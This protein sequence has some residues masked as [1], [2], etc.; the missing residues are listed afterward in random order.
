[1]YRKN[2]VKQ[3]KEQHTT[4]AFKM[5]SSCTALPQTMKEAGLS[6]EIIG[7]YFLGYYKDVLFNATIVHHLYGMLAECQAQAAAAVKPHLF[8]IIDNN[9]PSG[10]TNNTSMCVRLN[11]FSENTRQTALL[12]LPQENNYWFYYNICSRF[13]TELPQQQ[14]WIIVCR[15]AVSINKFWLHSSLSGDDFNVKYPKFTH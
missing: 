6:I 4:A 5:I 11:F 9:F 7:H 13:R 14:I 1:M 10:Q 8:A 2:I 12:R 15:V 3:W